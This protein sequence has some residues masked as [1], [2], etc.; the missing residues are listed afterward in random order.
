MFKNHG[1]SEILVFTFGQECL[2]PINIETEVENAEKAKITW[3]S[4]PGQTEYRLSYAE[5]N[6]DGTWSDWYHNTG[7]LPYNTLAGLKPDTIPYKLMAT[8]GAIDS[9]YSRNQRIST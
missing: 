9:K 1:Y 7:I 3:Q 2:P 8:C 5:Q 4:L 6:A